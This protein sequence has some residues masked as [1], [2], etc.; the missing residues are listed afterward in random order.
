[1]ERWAP[2]RVIIQENR[3]AGHVIT[4]FPEVVVEDTDELLATYTFA[5]STRIDGVMHKRPS[6][7]LEERVRV[8]SMR[9]PQPLEER[10]VRIHVLALN[11]PGA[12]HSFLVLWQPDW[13]FVS[14]YVNLQHPF[15]RTDRGIAFGRSD[16]GDLLLDIIVS[17]EFE[18]SWKDQD[19]FDAVFE[20]GIMA[21]ADRQ[22]ALDESKR[23]IERIESRGWPFNEDWP[24]WRPDPAWPRPDLRLTG[25][26]S[27]RLETHRNTD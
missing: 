6:T 22:L 12:N 1:M 16:A 25:P 17:P 10:P 7:T 15:E 3:Y 23:M 14:W 5:S 21:A 26:R 19:E 27:W 24:S 18:W 13:T 2:G 11:P 9:D 20:A 4:A 8:Y